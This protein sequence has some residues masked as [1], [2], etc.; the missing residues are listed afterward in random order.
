MSF[1]NIAHRGASLD[2]AEN[3]LEAF[4][5]AIGQGADMI[6]TDLHLTRDGAVVLRHDSEHEGDDIG[7]LT[8][9]ELR[10][11]LPQV[12]TLQEAMD[13][14][15]GRIPFNLELK[16][17]PEGAYVGLETLVIDEV[18]RRSMVSDTL[19]SC[20]S[21][22]VLRRIR[23]LEPE[24]RVALLVGTRGDIETCARRVDAEAVHLPLRLATPEGISGLQARDW[25]VHVYTVDDPGDQ[26]RLIDWGVDGI[27]TN[28]PG[29]LASILGQ[30]S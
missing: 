18:R 15:E 21:T 14:V 25:R 30:I 26:R 16:R 10:E 17:P 1:L 22:S 13:A 7:G 3:T 27:F 4:E 24:A 29:R 19:F 8:L 2:A 11:R 28:A 5:L 12:P 20:F 9:A 6:E 23:E